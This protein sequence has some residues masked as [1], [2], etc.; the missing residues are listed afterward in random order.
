M[1]D[2]TDPWAVLRVEPDATLR[3]LRAARRTLAKS[4]HPDLGGTS[5]DMARINAAFEDASRRI[6]EPPPRV[7]TSGP[8]SQT[9][10]TIW[11]RHRVEHDQPSFVVHCLPA[12]A[13]EDLLLVAAWLGDVHDHDPPYRLDVRL[14]EPEPCFCR[15]ELV[16]DAG[17]ST[18]SMS[19]EW[20]HEVVSVDLDGIRDLWIAGLNE[21]SDRDL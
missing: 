4:A 1:N 2:A 18:V 17:A 20:E 7:A 3:Q 21:L 5:V 11:R 12:E 14:H 15:L 10:G 16:P 19:V 9:S 13:F 6:D 8:R